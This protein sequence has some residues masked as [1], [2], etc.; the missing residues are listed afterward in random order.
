MSRIV[1]SLGGNA[2]GDS[3][4]EQLELVKKAVKPIVDLVE[5][6]HEVIVIH[7]NGPQV[8]SI[9]LLKLHQNI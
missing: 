9:R 1:I 3:P 6:G 4:N 7:G 8:G 5:Q 2:L